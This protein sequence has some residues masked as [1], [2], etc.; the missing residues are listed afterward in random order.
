MGYILIESASSVHDPIYMLYF[1][2][3]VFGAGMEI[4]NVFCAVLFV[5]I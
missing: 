3:T 1:E 5:H 2:E 4:I